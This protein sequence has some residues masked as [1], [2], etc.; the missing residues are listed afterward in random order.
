MVDNG[1][2]RYLVANFENSNF[3]V[4]KCLFQEG[5]QEQIVSIYPPA[6]ITK[7]K[8]GL[9]RNALI[10]IIVACVVVV[11]ILLT[12][13]YIFYRYKK[14]KQVQE[15]P[16]E[17]VAA[18]PAATTT[19]QKHVS[20]MS[21]MNGDV[22][23]QELDSPKGHVKYPSDVSEM[24]GSEMRHELRTLESPV[25]LQGSPVTPVEYRR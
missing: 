11:M 3:S 6:Q 14:R 15:L 1:S 21:E 5:I 19:A 24:V 2:L 7:V 12:G 4:S 23:R 22:P 9:G 10:G 25:E 17:S 20:D 13:G 16:A 8:T 18:T